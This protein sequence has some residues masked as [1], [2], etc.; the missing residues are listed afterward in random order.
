MGGGGS[1]CRDM[2]GG[3][4]AVSCECRDPHFIWSPQ[5]LCGVEA[6]KNM[7]LFVVC[8]PPEK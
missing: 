8:Y 3:K 1:V 2:R 5:A 4:C 6:S 7:Q